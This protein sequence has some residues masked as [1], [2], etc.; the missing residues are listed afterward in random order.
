MLIAGMAAFLICASGNL[1]MRLFKTGAVM[2]GFLSHLI[3]DEIYSVDV[4]GLRLKSSFGT[5]VKF[6]SDS[7]WGNF[8]TYAKLVIL[9][10][11]ALNDPI[12]EA[13]LPPEDQKIPQMASRLV[14][15]I[16]SASAPY[17]GGSDQTEVVTDEGQGGET[18]FGAGLEQTPTIEQQRDWPV[19]DQGDFH[20][21]SETPSRDPY[22]AVPR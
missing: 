18:G 22:P 10:I 11:A 13:E 8:S 12:W 7:A 9:T 21:M 5:A 6:W 20:R 1:E 3:L 16:K 4:R 15:R 17:L 19:V 2:L 14:D